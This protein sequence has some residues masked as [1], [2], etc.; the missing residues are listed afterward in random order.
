ME[1]NPKLSLAAS[2]AL[3]SQE[4]EAFY[5]ELRSEGYPF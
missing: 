3:I 1:T 5:S 4:A 2:Q